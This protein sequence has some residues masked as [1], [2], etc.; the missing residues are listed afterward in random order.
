[1]R[2][3]MAA[4]AIGQFCMRVKKLAKKQTAFLSGSLEMNLLTHGEN[5][6]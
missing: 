6:K 2:E 3:K 1:M 4:S 5:T